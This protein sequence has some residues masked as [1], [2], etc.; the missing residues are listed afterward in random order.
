MS[1]HAL[2]NAELAVMELLWEHG[3]LTARDLRERLYPDDG[4]AQHGTVQRLLAR[5]EEKAFV[6]REREAG[7][8][9]FSP[10]VS[11]EQYASGQLEALAERLSGGSLAPLLTHL[12]ES[13]RISRE[14]IERLRGVLDASDDD[15]KDELNGEG[16][17]RA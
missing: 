3:R 11:K 8:W 6:E 1:Q 10:R 2:A 5:L 7:V 12:V 16:E 17:E 15:S 13:R 9:R 4:K 14:E